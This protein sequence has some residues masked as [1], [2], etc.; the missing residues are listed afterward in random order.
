MNGIIKDSVDV[1]VEI[2]AVDDISGLPKTGLT[3]SDI[4]ARYVRTRSSAVAITPVSLGSPDSSHSDG[5][6][7]EIET[8][9]N[10]SNTVAVHFTVVV[11]R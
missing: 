1:T 6:F 5:G 2:F 4:T 10:S 7:I 9:G 11:R 8:D 3:H